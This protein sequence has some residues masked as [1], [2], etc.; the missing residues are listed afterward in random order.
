[1]K[2][3]SDHSSFHPRSLAT[4]PTL[5]YLALSGPLGIHVSKLVPNKPSSSGGIR[6]EQVLT[7]RHVNSAAS[8]PKNQCCLKFS[9][10]SDLKLASAIGSGVTLWDVGSSVSVPLLARLSLP[11]IGSSAA[12]HNNVPLVGT[13]QNFMMGNSNHRRFPSDVMSTGDNYSLGSLS[14]SVPNTSVNAD[15]KGNSTPSRFYYG[16][17]DDASASNGISSLSWMK[18]GTELLV[19]RENEI[20]MYDVRSMKSSSKPSMHFLSDDNDCKKNVPFSCVECNDQ[21]LIGTID[22]NGVVRLY[23]SRRASGRSSVSSC[24]SSFQAHD[25]FGAGIS[26]YNFEI[27]KNL[28]KSSP[29]ESSGWITWGYDA[30]S[31]KGCVKTWVG[32][33]SLNN[34]EGAIDSN[35]YWYEGS[36]TDSNVVGEVELRSE[37]RGISDFLK[38]KEFG[39]SSICCVRTCPF[40]SLVLTVDLLTMKDKNYQNQFNTT[41]W[42]LDNEE[43]KQLGSFVVDMTS[44]LSKIVGHKI[45][46]VGPLIASEIVTCPLLEIRDEGFSE[47]NLFLCCL[48]S[49]G[50]LTT[51]R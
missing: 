45:D 28:T 4:H 6:L 48:S 19:A 41:V 12:S 49:S 24:F 39:E 32:R 47:N 50:Y 2:T 14:V 36:L 43:N 35:L 21:G 22:R 3:V 8:N 20:F 33:D 18:S 26:S 23:D 1:M 25:G 34:E 42:E 7:I 31:A 5:N 46:N 44:E 38:R 15:Q 17:P 30:I 11:P 13:N 37:H 10:Q 40:S 29:N 27:S 16:K 51:Y 9:P